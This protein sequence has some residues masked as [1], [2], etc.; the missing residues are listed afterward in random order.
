MLHS[1]FVGRPFGHEPQPVPTPAHCHSRSPGFTP[2]SGSTITLPSSRGTLEPF[3]HCGHQ[4]G[5][6]DAEPTRATAARCE[7]CLVP[8]PKDEL[9]PR[10]R[11]NGYLPPQT[12][13]QHP[14]SFQQVKTG[15]A[16]ATTAT[17]L[18]PPRPGKQSLIPCLA[19]L[20]R[21]ERLKQQTDEQQKGKTAID[22]SLLKIQC[23]TIHGVGS[24]PGF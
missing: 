1:L 23:G 16:R 12:T 11:W 14:P 9:T 19:T 13:E 15:D 24:L 5:C 8:G 2:T 21:S 22:G 10:L 6:A 18:T 4:F 3:G 20:K 7:D 17:N